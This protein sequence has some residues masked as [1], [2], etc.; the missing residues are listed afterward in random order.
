MEG[1]LRAIAEPRRQEILR[2][3]GDGEMAS[4][5]IAA[6]F[7]VS[8]PAISQHLQVLKAAGLVTERRLGTRHLYQV[9]PEAIAQ[10]K[11][12]LDQFWEGSLA[13]LAEEAEAEQRRLDSERP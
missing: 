4:G 10:L 6:H 13:R 1:A 7:D 9:R 2:L 8:R 12:F 5:E 3:I 11:T